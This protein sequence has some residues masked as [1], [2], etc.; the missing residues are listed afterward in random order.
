MRREPLACLIAGRNLGDIVMWSG[1]IRQLIAAGYAER[2]M[3]WTR[4]KMV[5]MFQDLPQCEVLCSAFPMGTGMRFGARELLG[6]LD[7]AALI[8]SCAPSVV[9]DFVGDFRERFLARLVGGRHLHIGWGRGH[10]QRRMIR[11]P[12]G[13]GRPLVTV[14]ASVPNIYSGYHLM[15]EALT[16]R[17]IP[18]ATARGARR[19]VRRIGLHPF[20]SQ[21]SKLWPKERWRELA[22]AL[23]H[24]GFELWGFSSPEEGPELEVLFRDLPV[25]PLATDIRQYCLDIQQLDLVIGLDSL[26]MHM[27]QRYGVPCITINAGN[28]PELYA[29]PDGQTLADSGGCPR[30]PCYNTAPCRGTPGEH[31]CVRA[32]G[33]QQ[34]LAAVEATVRAR[35]WVRAA[36]SGPAAV[37]VSAG[38]DQGAAHEPAAPDGR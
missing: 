12:L 9:L 25:T 11:N 35:A 16:G 17:P 36:G 23:S 15:L 6:M 38:A 14:P 27:A 7:T 31:A 22:Q 1:L 33:T 4:P 19:R 3:V 5:C 10:A 13:S 20:A 24:Q 29:V 28:P 37:R 32:I 18:P 8:R 2:Y 34:V 26:S 30:H 21:P